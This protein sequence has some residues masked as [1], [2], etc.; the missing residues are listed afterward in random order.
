M[1]AEFDFSQWC[2]S[3]GLTPKTATILKDQ[4]LHVMEAVKLLSPSDIA[5]L[6]LT[7]GQNKLL[8]KAVNELRAPAQSAKLREPITTTSLA[9]GQGLHELLKKLD[10]GGGLDALVSC[11]GLYDLPQSFHSTIPPAGQAQGDTNRVDL[12]P[13]VYLGKPNAVKRKINPFSFP[14]LWTCTQVL[15]SQ[16]NKR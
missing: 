10:N 2:E 14:I 5:E 9:K 4:D 3:N 13:H 12:S 8:S 11:G 7:K 6:G 1:S 15:L 16:K